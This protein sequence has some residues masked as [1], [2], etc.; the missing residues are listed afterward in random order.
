MQVGP[1]IFLPLP[2]P[3][4]HASLLHL[5]PYFLSAPLLPASPL[6]H[7][8]LKTRDFVALFPADVL[9]SCTWQVLGKYSVKK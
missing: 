5:F 8:S 3:P 7:K 1:S 4:P 6:E 9:Q 2:S